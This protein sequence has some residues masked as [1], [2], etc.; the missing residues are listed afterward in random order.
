[1]RQICLGHSHVLVRASIIKEVAPALLHHTFYKDDVR[2]PAGFLPS[3]FRGEYG[4]LATPDQLTWIT[5]G[6]QGQA[7]SVHEL[8]VRAIVDQENAVFRDDRRWPR[9]G[10]PRV[11]LACPVRQDRLR[12]CFG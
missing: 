1:M 2:N 5:C 9:L 12:R 3:L 11:K 6:E 7:G 4:L 10:Y 8:I